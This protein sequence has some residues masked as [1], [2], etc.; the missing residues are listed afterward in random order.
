[1]PTLISSSALARRR[2]AG[3][4][5][6]ADF[7]SCT[8]LAVIALLLAVTTLHF[9]RQRLANG[10]ATRPAPAEGQAIGGPILP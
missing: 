6:Q 10:S 3:S 8:V 4:D 5:R 9:E 7:P 2:S 1:M